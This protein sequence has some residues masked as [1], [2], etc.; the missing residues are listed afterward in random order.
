[1]R[2]RLIVKDHPYVAVTDA[3]GKFSMTNLPVGEWSCVFWHEQVGFLTNLTIDGKPS[4]I[5]GA[6]KGKRVLKLGKGQN[7]LGRITV[8]PAAF[9]G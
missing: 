9:D 6:D 5:E 2:G 3:D 8:A 7:D 1:M 4:K